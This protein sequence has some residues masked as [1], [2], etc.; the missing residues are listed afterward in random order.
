MDLTQ[1]TFENKLSFSYAG[2]TTVRPEEVHQNAE[3]PVEEEY[4][5]GEREEHGGGE[6][7]VFPKR[8]PHRA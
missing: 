1:A 7:G 5:I 2:H 8:D 3:C 6:Y 4:S